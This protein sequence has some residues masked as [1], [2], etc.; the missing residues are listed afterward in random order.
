MRMLI[1][2]AGALGG[3]T[4]RAVTSLSWRVLGARI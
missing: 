2:G 1:V 3:C 4:V